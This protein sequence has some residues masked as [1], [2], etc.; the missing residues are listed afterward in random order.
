MMGIEEKKKLKIEERGLKRIIIRI[1]KI[2]VIYK[3]GIFEE[4]RGKIEKERKKIR[5]IKEEDILNMK[6]KKWR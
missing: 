1:V 3:V 4:L 2:D 5:K 6:G